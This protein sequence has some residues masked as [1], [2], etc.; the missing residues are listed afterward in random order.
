[1]REVGKLEIEKCKELIA[2]Q[3]SRRRRMT[4]VPLAKDGDIISK[5]KVE[6]LFCNKTVMLFNR[7]FKDDP[8][9]L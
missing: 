9:Y 2:A 4:F 5:I 7:Y 8:D 1:M 3:K 6:E